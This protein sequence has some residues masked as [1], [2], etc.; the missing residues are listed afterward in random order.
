MA[1]LA[2][3]TERE[4]ASLGII[5]HPEKCQGCRLALLGFAFIYQPAELASVANQIVSG[6][7]PRTTFVIKIPESPNRLCQNTRVNAEAY[8]GY[9]LGLKD[10]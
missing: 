10:P 4:A 7:D 6:T 3:I 8:G 1:L 2:N 9:C 5:R